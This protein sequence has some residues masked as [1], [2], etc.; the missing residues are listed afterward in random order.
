MNS[1]IMLTAALMSLCI[2][3]SCRDISG[4]LFIIEG[5]YHSSKGEWTK[6]ISSYQ[7]A[8]AYEEAAPY[9][10]AGLGSAYFNLNDVKAALKHFED[11]QQMLDVL[12]PVEHR[13]L[14]YLNSYNSGVAMF[15]QGNFSAAA[16]AFRQAL[17][18]DSGRIEAKRNLELSL[19]SAVRQK[20]SNAGLKLSPEE[21]DQ[22]EAVFKYIGLKERRQWERQEWEADDSYNGPDY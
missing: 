13:E 10:E 1:K 21:I 20:T 5:N 19:L 4:K 6:A 11:S 22:M 9:A 15:A 12:P 18:V 17:R 8:C 2:F 16:G 7:K 3:A 14:R